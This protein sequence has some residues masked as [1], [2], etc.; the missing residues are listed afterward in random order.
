VSTRPEPTLLENGD[1]LVPAESGTEMVKLRPGEEGHAEWLAYLQQERRQQERRP[2]ERRR[3]P[4]T[5]EARPRS[6]G[7]TAA[8]FGVGLIAAFVLVLVLLVVAAIVILNQ[9]SDLNLPDIP[10]L[11]EDVPDLP[12]DAPGGGDAQGR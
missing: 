11:P 5:R 9:V 4:R 10:G 8:G 7:R 12:E 6:V 2:Q 1:I 3:R